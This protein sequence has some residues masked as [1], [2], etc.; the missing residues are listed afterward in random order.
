[1]GKFK[2]GDRVVVAEVFGNSD[3]LNKLKSQEGVVKRNH[4]SREFPLKVYWNEG[5]DDAFTEDGWWWIE[6][7]GRF[8]NARIELVDDGFEGNV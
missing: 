8:N 4:D 6:T 5:G 1:M 3:Y 7:H 2:V